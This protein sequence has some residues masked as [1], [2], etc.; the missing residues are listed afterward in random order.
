MTLKT[1]QNG[2]RICFEQQDTARSAAMHIYI[3]AG[4]RNETEEKMECPIL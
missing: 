4:N 1:F 2:L 3:A